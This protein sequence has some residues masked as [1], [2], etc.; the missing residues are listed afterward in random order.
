MHLR[1]ALS[2][3]SG[4]KRKAA[5]SRTSHDATESS[6]PAPPAGSGPEPRRR[7]RRRG[8]SRPR[9]RTRRRGR[10]A[11]SR[12]DEASASTP[13]RPVGP[14]LRD[15]GLTHPG[16][17]R[18]RTRDSKSPSPTRG[19]TPRHG[20][21]ARQPRENLPL[22]AIAARH[23]TA[24]LPAADRCVQPHGTTR[25]RAGVVQAGEAP[26]RGCCGRWRSSA[27]T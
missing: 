17:L 26:F 25:A 4:V 8:R 9:R 19:S 1:P 3:F 2:F 20:E 12:R 13:A 27:S 5:S 23:S 18:V 24:R 21:S 7:R 10:P 16:R 14:L 6:T 15:V 22:R 11:Y